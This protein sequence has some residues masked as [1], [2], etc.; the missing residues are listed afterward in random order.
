MR[1]IMTALLAVAA[2]TVIGVSASKTMPLTPL[3]E[4]VAD[5]TPVETASGGCGFLG[6]RGPFGACRPLYSCPFGWHPGP[7]GQRCFRNW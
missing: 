2:V 5:A 7:F 6:H 3:A 1:T 4:A